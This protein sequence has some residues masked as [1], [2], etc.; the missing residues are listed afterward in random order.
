M[1]ALEIFLFKEI[2]HFQLSQA[3]PLKCDMLE[4]AVLNVI[5]TLEKNI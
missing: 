2:I 3:I 1:Y 5:Y 4:T